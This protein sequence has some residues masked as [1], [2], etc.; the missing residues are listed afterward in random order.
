MYMPDR[1]E[2]SIRKAA[3]GDID[4]IMAVYDSA[5]R[6]M[7]SNGNMNQWTG[8]YPSR[9][10]V[11][12]DISRGV[13]HV[14]TDAAGSISAVF[15][16]IVGEDPTY[17]VII[18]GKWPDNEPYGTIHRLASDGRYAGILE[19]CVEYCFAKAD[20][21]RLDTHEDN[22]PM[23]TAVSRL[24]FRRCGIIFCSDGTPRIAYCKKRP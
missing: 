11:M 20:N 4:D 8:G 16:F 14:I 24:G 21:L 18:N 6:F 12:D 17:A 3:T 1:N 9:D 10:L 13:C 23:R 7:R 19:I 2:I 22:A 5:R 15:A